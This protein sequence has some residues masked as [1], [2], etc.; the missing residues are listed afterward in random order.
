MWFYLVQVRALPARGRAGFFRFF[1]TSE[2]EEKPQAAWD[3]Q[4][5]YQRHSVHEASVSNQ[6]SW[7][8][9]CHGLFEVPEDCETPT[10]AHISLLRTKYMH[11]HSCGGGGG[12]GFVSPSLPGY[13]RGL[14]L[15]MA[16]LPRRKLR[17]T[18]L[19]SAKKTMTGTTARTARRA[20]TLPCKA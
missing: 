8:N 18:V 2:I 4:P 16:S 10:H 6:C 7:A 9:H 17:S 20:R 12:G 3:T 11:T 19:L 13:P 1:N 5:S 14:L 15:L